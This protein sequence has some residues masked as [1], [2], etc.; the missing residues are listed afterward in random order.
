MKTV[1]GTVRHSVCRPSGAA[2][3][4]DALGEW[5]NGKGISRH[6]R[7]ANRLAEFS[8][9]ESKSHI[10]GRTRFKAKL[11]FGSGWRRARPTDCVHGLQSSQVRSTTNAGSKLLKRFTAG[12]SLPKNICATKRHWRASVWS[13]RSRLR[14]STAARA[15]SIK[16]K[17]TFGLLS[18]AR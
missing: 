4:D 1:G 15:R 12:I 14:C 2:W 11:K 3:T 10:A 6:T 8:A 18:R 13:I 9:S 16:S 7:T 17:I 5:K